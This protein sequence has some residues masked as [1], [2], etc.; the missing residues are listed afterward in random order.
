LIS[1]QVG[2]KSEIVTR[3]EASLYFVENKCPEPPLTMTVPGTI[4]P[5][6][7]PILLIER[8]MFSPLFESRTPAKPL[9]NAS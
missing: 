2:E 4:F 3:S 5:Q 8:L 9:K 1:R 7:V 6:P